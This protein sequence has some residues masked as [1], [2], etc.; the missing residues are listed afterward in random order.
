M[1][2]HVLLHLLDQMLNNQILFIKL[3]S[4]NV[5]DVR[6][7]FKMLMKFISFCL[8]TCLNSCNIFIC[9][10]Q[11]FVP[12]MFKLLVLELKIHEF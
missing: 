10:C 11:K 2:N 8:I 3:M 9:S 6:N 5:C 12:M 4:S 7:L 1:L